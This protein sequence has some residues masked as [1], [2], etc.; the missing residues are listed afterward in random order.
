LLW[1]AEIL[2]DTDRGGA[3][4]YLDTALTL[5]RAQNRQLLL[6]HGE[7]LQARLL[8]A[9]GDTASAQARLV[10]LLDRSVEL[11]LSLEVARTRAA[12]ARV[13]LRHAPMSE[14]GRA[15]LAE[16]LRGLDAHG[17]RA[18]HGALLALANSLKTHPR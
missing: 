10:E 1:L 18:E 12:L 5:A 13:T 9:G 6:L 17:A 8:A 15:L 14:S 16:A 4:T 3:G 11:G 7:R 2:L